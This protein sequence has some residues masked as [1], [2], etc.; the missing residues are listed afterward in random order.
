[1]FDRQIAAAKSF[2]DILRV[3]RASFILAFTVIFYSLPVRYSHSKADFRISSIDII[4]ISKYNFG[5]DNKDQKHDNLVQLLDGVSLLDDQDKERFTAVVDTLACTDKV[6][7]NAL[8][9][10]SPL[11]T[12][13]TSVYAD[14]K[15]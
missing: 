8:F 9:S 2:W 5:M 11:K 13:T 10:D 15:I 3:L 12:E 4:R 6:V 14:E 7:G 1:M